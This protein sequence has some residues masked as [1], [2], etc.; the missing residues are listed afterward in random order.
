[1]T[2]VEAILIG[3]LKLNLML[4]AA[5]LL[6]QGYK[7]GSGVAG[8][9]WSARAGVQVARLLLLSALLLP[10]LIVVTGVSS[11]WSDLIVESF[12]GA[13]S[14]ALLAS[15]AA[16]NVTAAS[17]IQT[18]TVLPLML[19]MLLMLGCAWQLLKLQQD[20]R[21]LRIVI[22]NAS[23]LKHIGHVRVLY[24]DD[25]KI[26]LA[27]G[28][29]ASKYIV[30]PGALLLSQQ[31]MLLTLKHEIQH[32]RAG[33]LYYLV[34]TRLLKISCFWNPVAKAWFEILYQMQEL[35]CD[36]A[37]TEQK[38]VS[39]LAYAECLYSVATNSV[40][41]AYS[42]CTTMNIWGDCRRER[43][44]KLRQ[45]ITAICKQASGASGPNTLGRS[46]PMFLM[47]VLA[48]FLFGATGEVNSN[49]AS[50]QTE[51]AGRA[52]PIAVG[53]ESPSNGPTGLAPRF[54]PDPDF[55][56]FRH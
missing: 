6:W 43:T 38:S 24:S 55:G 2:A 33:D 4:L 11:P 25:I 53:W 5:W 22:S 3:Y 21:Q 9:H 19:L 56:R 31:H 15:P 52:E 14:A 49:E 10:L 46:L 29:L 27:T 50:E 13:G 34:L 20:Y 45:R 54:R 35:A 1:M 42:L 7:I 17:S 26:P 48:V 16:G 51:F 44:S 41:G 30:L 18:V 39:R 8:L 40:P 32:I 23:V 12:H 47:S 28:L 36:E 37:V